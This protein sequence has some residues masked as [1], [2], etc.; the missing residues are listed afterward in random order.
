M[1]LRDYVVIQLAFNNEAINDFTATKTIIEIFIL[2]II[3]FKFCYASVHKHCYYT[4][5]V[6]L[7]T[8]NFKRYNFLFVYYYYWLLF[9]LTLYNIIVVITSLVY[10]LRWWHAFC[11]A[12]RDDLMLYYTFGW[13]ADAK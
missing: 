2:K 11:T 8:R 1:I 6:L 3:V 10:R 13:V 7:S 9:V 5:I 4:Q 12:T